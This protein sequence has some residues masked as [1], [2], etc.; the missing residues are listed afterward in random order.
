M[1]ARTY[2]CTYTYI[3]QHSGLDDACTI[4]N[5]IG[6]MYKPSYEKREAIKQMFTPVAS[7]FLKD[8]RRF[9]AKRG[10]MHHAACSMHHT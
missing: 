9:K 8:V 6:K 3:F 7:N 10:R 4:A 5:I 2:T 1:Y